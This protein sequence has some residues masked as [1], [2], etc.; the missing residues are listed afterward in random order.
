M[1]EIF[2]SCDLYT[3]DDISRFIRHCIRIKQYFDGQF[4]KIEYMKG[5]VMDYNQRVSEF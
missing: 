2:K 3:M 4:C 1:Y 5:A